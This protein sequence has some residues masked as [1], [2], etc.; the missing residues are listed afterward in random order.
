MK[1]MHGGLVTE[2]EDHVRAS[3]S[4]LEPVVTG[5]FDPKARAAGD[6]DPEPVTVMVDDASKS[7]E[8]NTLHPELHFGRFELWPRLIAALDVLAN[9][10]CTDDP[11][12][13]Q[14]LQRR[15]VSAHRLSLQDGILELSL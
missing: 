11:A 10:M 14:W 3:A 4:T 7:F 12:H 2:Y 5:F 9:N 1:T 15:S 8:E 13:A 6:P